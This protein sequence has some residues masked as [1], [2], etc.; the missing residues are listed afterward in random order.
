MALARCRFAVLV[1]CSAHPSRIFSDELSYGDQRGCISRPVSCA[2]TS[3][4]RSAVT[5]WSRMSHSLC[6]IATA[7]HCNPPSFLSTTCCKWSQA[8]SLRASS[9]TDAPNGSRS[10]ALSAKRSLNVLLCP[11]WVAAGFL[12][13]HLVGAGEQCRG[14]VEA[15]SARS[16]QI[17]CKYELGRLHHRQGGGFFT[18]DD[19][20][21]IDTGLSKRLRQACSVAHQPA[22]FGVVICIVNG[23]QHVTRCQ[24][25]DLDAPVEEQQHDQAAIGLVCKL[26]D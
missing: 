9:A 19:S 11:L 20:A 5:P 14:N 4:A 18:F 16:R 13:D 10:P 8:S 6:S 7:L 17:Y 24:R 1:N 12:I 23:R 26:F 15:E 22:G 21:G 3:V 25:G 2:P